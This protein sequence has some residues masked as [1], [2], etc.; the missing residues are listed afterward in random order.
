LAG[1]VMLDTVRMPVSL[2]PLGA[3]EKLLVA[4]AGKDT[5]LL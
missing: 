2:S 1:T 4:P 3:G 5:I